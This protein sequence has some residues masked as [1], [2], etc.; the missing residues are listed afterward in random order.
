[1]TEEN[2]NPGR[3]WPSVENDGDGNRYFDSYRYTPFTTDLEFYK[4]PDIHETEVA[5]STQE[6]EVEP[7]SLDRDQPRGARRTDEQI[8]D[9]IKSLLRQHGQIDASDI[10][11]DVM[12]GVVTLSGAVSGP[13]EME[14]AEG[15]SGNVI[16]V[17]KI[18]NKMT[19][20]R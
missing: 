20:K 7:G 12:D 4:D 6:G 14:T 10:Y 16:G 19:I 18:N 17:L 2:Q 9:E 1:M 13:M 8:K 15:I 5:R 11:V 3:K